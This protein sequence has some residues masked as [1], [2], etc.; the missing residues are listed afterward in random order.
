MDIEPNWL[1]R[2]ADA[3]ASTWFVF[4]ATL[5]GTAAYITKSREQGKFSWLDLLGDLIISSFSGIITA[6]VCFELKWDMYATAAACGVA[7]HQGSRA[8][9]LILI[10]L[11]HLKV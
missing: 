11:R 7:G 5:G 10:Y 9:K 3:A 1:A 2:L 4:L 6:Y 8:L